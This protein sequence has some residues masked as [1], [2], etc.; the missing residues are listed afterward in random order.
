MKNRRSPEVVLLLALAVIIVISCLIRV[1]PYLINGYYF[2][3]GFDTGMYEDILTRFVE[4]NS[5]DK[6]PAYPAM[7]NLEAYTIEPGFFITGS[8]FT[9]FSGVEIREAFRY[10]FPILF[11]IQILLITFVLTRSYASNWTAGLIAV[12]LA[13]VSY[14]QI[15]AVNESY[16][17]QLAGTILFLAIIWLLERNYRAEIS[18]RESIL[19]VILAGSIFAFH[20]AV[21]AVTLLLLFIL[22][23]LRLFQSNHPRKKELGFLILGSIAVSSIIWIPTFSFQLDS[24]L[25]MISASGDRIGTLVSGGGQWVHGGSIPDLFWDQHILV[26]YFIYNPLTV[27][28]AGIG[29]YFGF[30][31]K[32]GR[33]IPVATLFLTLYVG[34]WLFFGNR[35]LLNL[36]ILI[37]CLAAA[38]FVW[39][40]KTIKNRTDRRAIVYGSVALVSVVILANP[41]VS[42]L[43]YQAD[44]EPYIT[45][46]IEGVKWMQ[47]NIDKS[48]SVIFAPDYLSADLLQLDFTMAIWDYDLSVNDT[49]PKF[50]N[51]EFIVEAPQN[52]SYLSHFLNTYEKFDSNGIYV[53]WGEWD[54]DRPLVANAEKIPVDDYKNSPYFELEYSGHDEILSIYRFIGI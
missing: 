5:W 52:R 2:E 44:K 37:V 7:H 8:F 33:V 51:A 17:K 31:E 42:M 13:A 38:G 54:L 28:L 50:T 29:G 14:V 25:N 4:A 15:N 22:F 26:A 10:F 43:F 34:L 36:D 30:R 32:R 24:L 46:N 20:R 35:F 9:Q 40:V 21:F 39:L 11:G 23:I 27:L 41:M 6:L 45:Q 19:I 18:K 47:E 53:L 12:A 1:A 3:V 48:S 49:H 16:Y